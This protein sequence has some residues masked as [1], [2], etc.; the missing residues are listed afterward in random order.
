M[1]AIESLAESGELL[2]L[3][4]PPVFVTMS[5]RIEEVDDEGRPIKRTDEEQEDEHSGEGEEAAS[6]ENVEAAEPSSKT[7]TSKGKK[8]K[9]KK[10]KKAKGQNVPQEVVDLVA[11]ELR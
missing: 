4:L 8:S 1:N 3:S 10:A 6:D 11:T 5:A 2:S 9:K 7:T